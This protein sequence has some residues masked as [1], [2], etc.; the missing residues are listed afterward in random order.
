M[1]LDVLA[2][3]LL[4]RLLELINYIVVFPVVVQLLLELFDPL[5]KLFLRIQ[6]VESHLSDLVLVVFFDLALPVLDLALV[7]LELLLRLLALLAVSLL[8]LADH[9]LDVG[10]LAG[11]LQGVLLARDDAVGFAQNNLDF[12]LVGAGERGL[13]LTVLLILRMQVE[14]YLG[15]LGYLL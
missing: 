4:V 11:F 9:G 1:F 6:H 10:L 8:D 2:E 3:L 7:L 12:L 5:L 15:Q 14:D 13:E